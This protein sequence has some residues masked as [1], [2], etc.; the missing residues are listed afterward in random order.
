MN[1]SANFGKASAVHGVEGGAMATT[2][3]SE[4][5]PAAAY[6]ETGER[7]ECWMCGTVINVA[8]DDY[9]GMWVCEHCDYNA[10]QVAE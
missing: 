7:P 6:I 8:Y 1:H 2:I 5:D 3:R 9:L 10:P 4:N